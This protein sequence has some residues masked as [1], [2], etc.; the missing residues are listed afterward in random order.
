VQVFAD[1]RGAAG[2]LGPQLAFQRRPALL[3]EAGGLL[4]PG[5]RFEL[6]AQL[7]EL[8]EHAAVLLHEA[9]H[10]L[11]RLGAGR[12]L[13]ELIGHGVAGPRV[14]PRLAHQGLEPA[15]VA[16][17]R[18]RE[19]ARHAGVRLPVDALIAVEH[20]GHVRLG[21]GEAVVELAREAPG[22]V[23]CLHVRMMGPRV[24][25]QRADVLFYNARARGV[26]RGQGVPVL[27][28]KC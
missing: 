27:G 12:G 4:G 17:V 2:V 10:R 22:R 26:C 1:V 20:L 16:A 7:R 19:P 25:V 3:G 13:A 24:V 11:R 28:G 6:G 21:P 18:A 9:R 23:V 14:R 5:P 15:L 8:V